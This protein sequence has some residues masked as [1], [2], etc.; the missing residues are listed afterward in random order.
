MSRGVKVCEHLLVTS[1]GFRWWPAHSF[2]SLMD[3]VTSPTA[4]DKDSL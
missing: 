2:L 1:P 4:G 3:V